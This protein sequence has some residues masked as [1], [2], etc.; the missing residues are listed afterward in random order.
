MRPSLAKDAR[1][2]AI[3]VMA[4]VAFGCGSD[5]ISEVL[6]TE[7][8]SEAGGSWPESDMTATEVRWRLFELDENGLRGSFSF[9]WQNEK[10]VP[11]LAG[12]ELRFVDASGFEI[13]R[14][15][16]ADYLTRMVPAA[17]TAAASGNFVLNDV[18]TIEL[19]NSI[20][21][22]EVWAGFAPQWDDVEVLPLQLA[23]GISGEPYA[24]TLSAAGGDG[25]YVWR[26]RSGN[27]PI[28][29]S[30]SASGVLSGTPTL[31][32][33]E[34]VTFEAASAGLVGSD[35]N[36]VIVIDRPQI[37][38]SILPNGR[39]GFAY[40]Q[41]LQMTGGDVSGLGD[42]WSLVSGDLPPG[43]ALSGQGSISGTPN[44]AGTWTFRV[45]LA[46]YEVSTEGDITIT[47]TT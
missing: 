41:S 17:G 7:V 13:D 10:S 33:R 2:V 3:Y 19:A 18:T 20:A 32:S 29:L 40:F 36:Y 12:Y 23:T 31:R 28:G 24:D 45:R 34:L 6:I 46:V 26:V 44:Q 9:T 27:L 22:L 16:P 15:P 25:T 38:S 14:Y 21:G 39:V 1:N 42:E 37:T 47:I 8:H 35:V 30:L 5:E 43:L 4:L 11:Q